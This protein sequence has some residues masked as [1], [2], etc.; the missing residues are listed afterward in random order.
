MTVVC[1]ST[2]SQD[3]GVRVVALQCLVRIMSLY[4]RHL[5]PY[6][7]ALFQISVQAMKDANDDVMLQG[8]EFWSNVCD[9]LM[10]FQTNKYK[11]IKTIN[12]SIIVV[13]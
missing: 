5:E 8:I 12:L 9:L 6:I 4:Y 10:D 3:T 1:N 2:L 13:Y 7:A 11:L